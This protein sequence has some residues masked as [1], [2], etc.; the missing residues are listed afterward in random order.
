MHPRLRAAPLLAV[1]AA[2]LA[3]TAG[4]A[5]AREADHE[6]ALRAVQAG[7]VLPLP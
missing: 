5:P 4:P 6:R 2:L 7:E 1:F 3:L